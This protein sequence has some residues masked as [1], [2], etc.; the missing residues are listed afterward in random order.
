M[1]TDVLGTLRKA[2]AE[3]H[4]EKSRVDR[5]ISAVETAL[6]ALNGQPSVSG[7]HRRRRRMSAAARRAVGK[8]MKAYWAKRRA[9]AANGK[10]RTSK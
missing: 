6:S 10:R 5:H 7:S 2:L 3:L 4:S 8:R 1:A 9:E